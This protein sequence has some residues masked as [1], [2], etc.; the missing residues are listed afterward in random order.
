MK[1]VNVVFMGAESDGREWRELAWKLQFILFRSLTIG[2]MATRR[3][4]Q[5]QKRV[6]VMSTI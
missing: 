6:R 3:V 1:C 4:K 5:S 2:N